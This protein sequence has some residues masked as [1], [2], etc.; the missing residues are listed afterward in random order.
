M[1]T[2]SSASTAALTVALTLSCGTALAQ[3]HFPADDLTHFG[4]ADNSWLTEPPRYYAGAAT[5][6][7]SPEFARAMRVSTSAWWGMANSN[8]TNYSVGGIAVM[9]GQDALPGA[10][11]EIARLLAHRALAATP[12]ATSTCMVPWLQCAAFGSL[13]AR[14]R[15]QHAFLNGRNP[16]DDAMAGRRNFIHAL[17]AGMRFDFPYTR[18]AAHGPWFVQLRATRRSSAFKGSLHRQARRGVSLTIG[19]EF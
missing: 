17:S 6:I 14:M 12:A 13:E 11:V 1:A 8:A 18:T 16:D 9:L 2:F 19:T 4:A 3:A 7:A 5:R 10:P 15:A